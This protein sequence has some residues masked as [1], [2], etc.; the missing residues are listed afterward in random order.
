MLAAVM[1]SALILQQAN[2]GPVVW[3][4]PAELPPP[5]EVVSPVPAIPDSARA[6]PFGYERAQCSPLIRPAA[7]SLEACQIRIRS[8]LAANMGDALPAG[9]APAG[10]LDRCRQ[11]AAGDRYALQCGTPGRPDRPS[12]GL[13]EQTCESRPEPLPQGGVVWTEECRPAGATR[14]SGLGLKIPLGGD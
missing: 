10:S 5:P 4:P 8:I 3:A 2:P 1:M 9:L 6:D 13:Q 7:E 11:E 14:D 12:T